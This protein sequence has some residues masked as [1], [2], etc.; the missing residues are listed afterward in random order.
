MTGL[1]HAITT[2]NGTASLYSAMLALGV[3]P[4]DEVISSTYNW[5]CSIAPAPLLGARPIFCDVDPRTLL[6]DPADLRRRI[7]P[8]TKAIVVVHLWGLVCDLDQIMAVSRETGVPVIEDCSHAHGATYRGKPVGTFGRIACWSLQGSKPVSA[9]EGGVLATDDLGAFERSCLIG[10]AN[11][12]AGMD[13]ATTRYEKYQPLGT[14]M[15]FRAHPV[16]IGIA[17]V[18]LR[19]LDALNAGRRGWVA[20]I[21]AGIGGE[22]S[23]RAIRSGSLGER[24]S[25]N[26][27]LAGAGGVPY[28][29][30]VTRY[31]GAGQGGFYG[32][33]VHF[34]PPAGSPVTAAKFA[35]ALKAE[36]VAAHTNP[37]PL[38][39]L[40]PYFAEG[41]DLFTGG[42][43]PMTGGYPGYRPGD[44]PN[45]ER[46]VESLLFLPVLTD[47]VGGA[48]DFVLGA[49]NRAAS[50][51]GLVKT[52]GVT[53]HEV[54]R[55][56]RGP[57]GASD[58]AL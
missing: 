25:P 51:L 10:Q 32:F 26:A 47:P 45:S 5:I 22:R 41:F 1:K 28:L 30:P 39:H 27:S 31:T 3:G 19:K 2:S 13:L 48:T 54:V 12:I 40:L 43:G 46:M 18:Q 55:P 17:A 24:S 50:S 7:T 29:E 20:A 56:V 4:G 16:A 58:K 42:R 53:S 52:N 37:Y 36:G 33:P 15:K 9:G 23:S 11:R 49:I 8:R 14:G 57:V 35:E 21:E 38:L 34:R 6:T 44:L